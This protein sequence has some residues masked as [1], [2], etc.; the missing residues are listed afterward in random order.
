MNSTPNKLAEQKFYT[1][2]LLKTIRE[3]DKE[4]NKQRFPKRGTPLACAHDLYIKSIE[5]KTDDLVVVHLGLR[6][7]PPPNYK[8]V[9]V[10]RSSITN[11]NWIMQNSPSQGDPDF[12]G[13]YTIRFRAIPIGVNIKNAIKN[14]FRRE[15]QQELNYSPF[16]YK[17]GERCAQ[18]FLECIQKFKFEEVEEFEPTFRGDNGYGSTGV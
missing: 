15:K 12:T 11:T 13:E 2:P 3:V 5:Q 4:G 14:L 7:Q 16:P 8:V 17:I 18:M 9:F 6:F 1:K 10:P